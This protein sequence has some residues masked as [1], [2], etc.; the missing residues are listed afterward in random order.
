MYDTA[1]GR[2]LTAVAGVG[3]CDRIIASRRSG[4]AQVAAGTTNSAVAN[5]GAI[6]TANAIAT[7]ATDATAR[8]GA[9]AGFAIRA[10]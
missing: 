1:A 6:G 7:N 8:T 5:A 10:S 4:S 2:G 3:S 9:Q